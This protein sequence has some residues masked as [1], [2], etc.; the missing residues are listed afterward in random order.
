MGG[1]FGPPSAIFSDSIACDLRRRT[2]LP[3]RSVILHLLPSC[4][5]IA[6]EQGDNHCQNQR[7]EREGEDH[8]GAHERPCLPRVDGCR[9]GR[10][11]GEEQDGE[12]LEVAES[13]VTVDAEGDVMMCVGS[14]CFES[15]IL[16]REGIDH[17]SPR[18]PDACQT[19]RDVEPV[20]AEVWVLCDDD[21][22][23]HGH[24]G[25]GDCPT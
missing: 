23:N 24:Q 16:G 25:T 22:E 21:R 5:Q 8:I 1:G 20:A 17:Q 19:Q 15:E 11:H 4:C 2:A 14:I 6:K 12:C 3:L 18:T 13:R 7:I 9:D 10:S